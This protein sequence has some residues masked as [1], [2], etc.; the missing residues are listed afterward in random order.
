VSN[1]EIDTPAE[2]P[3]DTTNAPGELEPMYHAVDPFTDDI[4]ELIAEARRKGYPHEVKK[5]GRRVL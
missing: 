2:T 5:N 3:R 1:T 4:W